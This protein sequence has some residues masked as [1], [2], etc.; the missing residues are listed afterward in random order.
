MHL[1]RFWSICMQSR[2][3]AQILARFCPNSFCMQFSSKFTKTLG[4][5]LSS[6]K[7]KTNK[8]KSTNRRQRTTNKIAD[9][10]TI[11]ADLR[12]FHRRISW[13]V[14]WQSSSWQMDTVIWLPVC[15][16]W[17]K[18]SSSTVDKPFLRKLELELYAERG[19]HHVS[20]LSYKQYSMTCG[21]LIEGNNALVDGRDHG[22]WWI[23]WWGLGFLGLSLWCK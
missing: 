5:S 13:C 8:S 15:S 17:C 20:F 19:S 21:Q 10:L 9:Q 6:L 3:A 14:Q 23:W 18:K 7:N 11:L 12:L 4:C 2:R 16:L 1:P 22:I